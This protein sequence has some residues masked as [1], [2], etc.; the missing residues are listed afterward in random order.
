[1][2]S[3]PITAVAPAAEPVLLARAKQY[4]RIED[5]DTSLDDQIG[6]FIAGVRGDVEDITGSRL[7]TQSVELVG[8]FSDFDRLPIGPVQSIDAIR[9]VDQAGAEQV[10]DSDAFR[11][12][13]AV[14]DWSIASTTGAAWPS[15]SP[16]NPAVRV[17]LKVG[18][19]D[20]GTDVPRALYIAMLRAIR[21]KMDE[22]DFDLAAACVNH[23]R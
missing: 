16:T 14:L 9:Y 13:G 22:I 6:D 11:L 15:T 21:A 20:A 1:M 8:R 23:R 3:S 18:Y 5:D 7:I 10:L 4:L 2:W 19:G 12:D 17:T